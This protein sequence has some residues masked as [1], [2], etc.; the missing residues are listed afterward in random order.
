LLTRY[1]RITGGDNDDAPTGG[2]SVSASSSEDL[3]KNDKYLIATSEQP[4]CALHR[5]GWFEEAELPLRYAGFSTC[6]RKEVGSHGKD[7]L[8]I[9]RYVMC[10]MSI[11]LDKFLIAAVDPGSTSLTKLSSSASPLLTDRTHGG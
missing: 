6:F 8:G 5:K 10:C 9:F 2:S 1:N 3:G 11:A 4:M 7:T